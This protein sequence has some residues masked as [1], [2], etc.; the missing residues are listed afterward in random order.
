MAI[1]EEDTRLRELFNL[2]THSLDSSSVLTVLVGSRSSL[3]VYMKCLGTDAFENCAGVRACS[4]HG[5]ETI[6]ANKYSPDS[7]AA[8]I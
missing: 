6:S 7:V 1:E 5:L 8:Y 4:G 3:T 2:T